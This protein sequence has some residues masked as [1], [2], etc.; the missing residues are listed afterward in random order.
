[1]ALLMRILAS[2]KRCTTESFRVWGTKAI[3]VAMDSI[4]A[5]R[6]GYR[7]IIRTRFE[8]RVRV[9]RSIKK[10][11]LNH[12]AIVSTF[13]ASSKSGG[14]QIEVGIWNNSMDFDC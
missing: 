3:F 14:I 2:D 8:R 10:Y 9:L 12:I 7:L 13:E 11:F 5:H 6:N 1:M 4:L